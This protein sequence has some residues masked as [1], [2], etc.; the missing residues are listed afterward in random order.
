MGMAAGLITV[1]MFQAGAAG[2]PMRF[3]GPTYAGGSGVGINTRGTVDVAP[4]GNNFD[5]APVW[6]R[7][8]D[9]QMVGSVFPAEAI[10]AGRDGF[11]N[12]KCTLT[13]DGALQ[14][15]SVVSETPGGMGFGRATLA[16][17]SDLNL[18]PAMKG[19]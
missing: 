7:V 14:G 8:P 16:L 19:G 9:P 4:V 3:D 12:I 2:A 13:V 6:I 5:T 17:T 18:K 1:L 11:A 10:R 15:C